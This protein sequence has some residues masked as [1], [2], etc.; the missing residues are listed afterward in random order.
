MKIPEIK[1]VLDHQIIKLK[2]ELT[3][4]YRILYMKQTIKKSINSEIIKNSCNSCKVPLKEFFDIQV[5][6][7]DEINWGLFIL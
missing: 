4:I 7:D 3:I 6:K 1:M 2:T 5:L